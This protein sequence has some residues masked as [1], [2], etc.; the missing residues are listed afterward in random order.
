MKWR[1]RQARRAAAERRP[2]RMRL[3]VDAAHEDRTVSVVLMGDIWCVRAAHIEPLRFPSIGEAE[4][5]GQ[6]VAQNLA[7]L[8][9]DARLDIHDAAGALVRTMRYFGDSGIAA[10]QVAAPYRGP[11]HS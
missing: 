11:L 8:G 9:F 3:P 5:A 4:E 10:A 7:T 6:G 1:S 2:D